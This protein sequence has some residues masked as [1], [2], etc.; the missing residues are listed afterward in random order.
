MSDV[1]HSDLRKKHLLHPKEFFDDP[2]RTHVKN[3]KD[4]LQ[5]G[6]KVEGLKEEKD[7]FVLFSTK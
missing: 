3:R 6:P 4:F 5:V 1:S 7:S 2:K